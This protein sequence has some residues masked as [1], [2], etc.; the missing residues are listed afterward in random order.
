MP[1]TLSVQTLFEQACPVIP[2]E[3]KYLKHIEGP[4]A[5]DP[6]DRQINTVIPGLTEFALECSQ[7]ARVSA[8]QG[9]TGR[10]REKQ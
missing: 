4:S 8:R 3:E 7:T 5:G 9:P 6:T 1:H 10:N 2:V